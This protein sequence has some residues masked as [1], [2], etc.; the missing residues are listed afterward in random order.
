VQVT[1]R[2]SV[3]QA[4]RLSLRR[5]SVG[6]FPLFNFFMTELHLAGNVGLSPVAASALTGFSLV[7]D[8]T[9][10]FA[11]STQ[12]TGKLFAAS[13][14]SPTPSILTTAASDMGA[15]FNNAIG[16]INPTFTNLA[17]GNYGL[18]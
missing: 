14:I 5:P 13:Y 9:G 11:T 15:A 18:S 3:N 17:S 6:F 10:T 16:R 12:V 7:L 2:Y 1:L 4:C 8:S